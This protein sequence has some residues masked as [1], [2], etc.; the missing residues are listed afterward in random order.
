MGCAYR[1]V[2]LSHP[3]I[4]STWNRN[5]WLVSSDAA[6]SGTITCP[7]KS[8][9]VMLRGVNW[10]HIDSGCD[11]VLMGRRVKAKTLSTVQ[12]KSPKI[13]YGKVVYAGGKIALETPMVKGYVPELHPSLQLHRYQKEAWYMLLLSHGTSFVVVMA[14]LIILYFTCLKPKFNLF[15]IPKRKVKSTINC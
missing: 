9:T 1:H 10:V 8:T 2:D 14:L 12:V 6:V 5:T 3:L 7:E 11:M 4:Q 15:K 13:A